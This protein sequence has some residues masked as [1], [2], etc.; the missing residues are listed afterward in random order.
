VAIT[1]PL[2]LAADVEIAPVARLPARARARLGARR[3]EYAITRPR[4]RAPAKLVSGAAAALLGEFRVARPVVEA[5]RLVAGRDG[6]DPARLLDE[7]YPL[8]RDCFN[9]R[10]L[11]AAGSPE[12]ARIL[13]SRD[14]GDMV[15]PFE[16][17][18]C[19]HVLE[20]SELY[21]VRDRRGAVAA[22]KLV[23][24]HAPPETAASLAREAA[25]LGLLAG[26]AAPRLIA[27]GRHRYRPW[28]AMSWRGGTAP[29]VAFGELRER[30]AAARGELLRLAVRVASA[31][32]RLHRAGVL[33]GDVHPGN[34]LI[35]RRG[36]V[37][38]LDFGLA[39]PLGGAALAGRA[40]TGGVA[41]YFA[42]EQAGALLAGRRLPVPTAASEQFAVAAMLYR[43]LTGAFAVTPV[44][45]RHG[46]LREI[47]AAPPRPFS[48]AGA[49]PWPAVEG[50]LARA[51]AR[52]PAQRFGSVGAMARALGRAADTPVPGRAPDGPPAG[53]AR[54]AAV[55]A[56][57]GTIDGFLA[58]V[59]LGSAAIA[60]P[61]PAPTCSVMLGRAGVAYAL[62]R[63]AYAREDPA[64]L[65]LADVWLTRVERDLADP[66]AF[67]APSQGLTLDSLGAASPFHGVPGV[68]LVRTLLALAMGDEAAAAAAARRFAETSQ[69]PRGGLDLTMGS[70]GTLMATARLLEAMPRGGRPRLRA[71]LRTLGDATLGEL[72]NALADLGPA[73][74]RSDLDNPGTAHGWAGIL[75]ATLGWCTA[76]GGPLPRAFRR[77][78]GELAAAA[79]PLGRGVR[80]A[81]PDAP[82]VPT[83]WAAHD[84][85]GWCNGPAGFALLWIAAH[86][87]W[88]RPAHL[89]LAEMCAWS[90]WEARTTSADLCCGA[91]G[92][93]YALLSL[94]RHT[95]QPAWLERARA[96]ASAARDGLAGAR[97]AL[98][99][100]LGLFKGEAGLAVL[101]A[102]L[103][104]PETAVFPLFEPDEWITPSD[105]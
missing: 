32:A 76:S 85:A 86:A 53:K 21:Q 31:Y 49:A 25:V 36:E 95:G 23:R 66:S 103:E 100:P 7:A 26:A 43:L 89:A 92:R 11:V 65:A 46:L 84:V 54:R 33:H 69:G 39:R 68:H 82:A 62:L 45:D 105:E 30:G 90:A 81:Q 10:F 71:A 40:S 78:L 87:R 50:V 15:G 102:D 70:A 37:T 2:V 5:V 52:D 8:L 55:G 22:V 80:W 64:P 47:A 12:A 93:A 48:R 29:D 27:R 17:L 61:G 60:S 44:P 88:R 28:L 1:D 67:E 97:A 73:G 16:V 98:E 6:R 77:R 9:A 34:L 83:V 59:G 94:Y 35:G 57:D 42:P 79:E 51:L 20:D 63:I 72:W 13:P 3:G 96:L 99:R 104:C 4:G 24:R 41:S 38:L 19:L 75:H 91:A 58:L 101:A 74:G 18:R 14:R 56:A